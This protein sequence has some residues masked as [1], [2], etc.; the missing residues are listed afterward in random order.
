[1]KEKP[2]FELGDRVIDMTNIFASMVP[3]HKILGIVL[4][5]CPCGCGHRWFEYQLSGSVS[6]TERWLCKSE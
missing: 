4:H 6:R 1:M 5:D 3:P 2:K